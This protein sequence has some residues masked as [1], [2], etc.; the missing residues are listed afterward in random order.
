MAPWEFIVAKNL[1][2]VHTWVPKFQTYGFPWFTW[3]W[4]GVSIDTMGF[5]MGTVMGHGVSW[6]THGFP[7][8]PW[9][10]CDVT[11]DPMVFSV[12]TVISHGVPWC[13]HGFS[14]FP[15]Y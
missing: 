14:W 9:Y 7:W 3:Y 2:M 4:C 13:A 8:L 6:C 11:I 12:G 15:W 10:Q 1:P 5:S